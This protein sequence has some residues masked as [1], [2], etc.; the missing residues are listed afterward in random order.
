[1]FGAQGID[2]RCVQQYVCGMKSIYLIPRWAG[3]PH[4]DWYDSFARDVNAAMPDAALHRLT[5]PRWDAPDTEEALQFLDVEIPLID[6]QT[7]FVGHSV[8]CIALV[9]FLEHRAR[10]NP[11]F[12]S[13]GLLLVAAWF[14]VDNPWPTLIPWTQ[15]DRLDYASVRRVCPRISVLLSDNDPHTHDHHA[16]KRLWED[17]MDARVSIHSG[18]AHFNGPEYPQIFSTLA[19]WT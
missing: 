13:G 5:M 2:S 17:R 9:H 7:V 11:G 3:R 14:N 6:E 16:N 10:L 15:N 19:A 1:M 4:S 12:R 8:G 18:C